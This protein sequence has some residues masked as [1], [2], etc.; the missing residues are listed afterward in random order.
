MSTIKDIID[1]WYSLKNPSPLAP[2]SESLPYLIQ[3]DGYLKDKSN[4][5]CLD[6]FVQYSSIQE[7]EHITSQQIRENLFKSMVVRKDITNINGK[8]LVPN[9]PSVINGI[10]KKMIANRP[11]YESVSH[12]FA[13]PIRWYH[14]AMIHLMEC[15]LSFSHY[16]GNGQPLNKKTT[17]A[18]KGRGAFKT[19]EEGAI[20]AIKYQKL[21]KVQD[22]SIGNALE[23]WERFNGWGYVLYHPDVNSPYLWSGTNHYIAGKYVSDGKFDKNA[24]STQIGIAPVFGEMLKLI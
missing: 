11:R 6:K 12:T 8:V 23:M 7:K 13:N 14:V 20:D 4:G 16:L 3:D 2:K 10:V 17:I 22:W 1:W 18:P 21:D 15:N 24:V 9:V 19:W 5:D